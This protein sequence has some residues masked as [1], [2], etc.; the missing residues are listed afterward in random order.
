MSRLHRHTEGLLAIETIVTNVLL[1]DTE[2][3]TEIEMKVMRIVPK[4][5]I[6]EGPRIHTKRGRS[7]RNLKHIYKYV[8]YFQAIQM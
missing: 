8:Q 2:K 6:T 5:T 4:K 7:G 1:T 3:L